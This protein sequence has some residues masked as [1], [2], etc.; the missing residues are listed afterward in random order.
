[1]QVG[2][3]RHT[4]VRAIVGDILQVALSER[5]REVEDKPRFGD[6]ALVGGDWSAAATQYPISPR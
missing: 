1:V 6:L 4:R 2:L 5:D 3:V